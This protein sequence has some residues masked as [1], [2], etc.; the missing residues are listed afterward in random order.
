[1]YPIFIFQSMQKTK[2]IHKINLTP[3]NWRLLDVTW[4]DFYKA[5]TRENCPLSNIN[6]SNNRLPK[7]V[8]NASSLL[9]KALR[10]NQV[11]YNV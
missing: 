6:S 3:N 4:S 7:P 1:M 11:K 5:D 9:N 2:Q 8:Q 10:S